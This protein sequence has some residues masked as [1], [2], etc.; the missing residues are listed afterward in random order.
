MA[1]AKRCST[2]GISYPP[3]YERCLVPDCQTPL[4]AQFVDPPDD[5][6]QDKV[7]EKAG[8]SPVY[9]A[10]H[11]P[12][13]GCEIR[14][15]RGHLFARHDDLITCGY[16]ALEA[17]RIVFLHDRF[18]ELAG[19]SESTGYWWLDEIVTEGAAD[20]LH[21]AMFERWDNGTED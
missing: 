4:W 2:C 11:P 21:P 17:G 10:A 14:E 3:Q 8:I 12:N 6:W 9:S 13:A 18:F 20:E 5:D 7:A 15:F 16:Q 1:T 19:Y